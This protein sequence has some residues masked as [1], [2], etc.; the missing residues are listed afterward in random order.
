MA[1]SAVLQ[2]ATTIAKTTETVVGTI[3]DTGHFDYLTLFLVYVNGDETGVNVY[4]YL[5]PLS[6]GTETQLTDWDTTSGVYTHTA[7]V[8]N[9]TANATVSVTID[10]RGIRFAKIY[11][12]GSANDGTPTGTLAVSYTVK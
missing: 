2:A 12:G 4:P 5:M 1:K 11:Q 3:I 6:T 10:V 8:I 9:F 7:Q